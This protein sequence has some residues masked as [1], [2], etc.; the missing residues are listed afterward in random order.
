[1]PSADYITAGGNLNSTAIHQVACLEIEYDLK[2][3]SALVSKSH[4]NTS[5]MPPLSD[6]AD[7]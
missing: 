6:H 3:Y 4:G 1:M 5:G 2:K 7:K